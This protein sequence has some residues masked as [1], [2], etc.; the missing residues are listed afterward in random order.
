MLR[1]ESI[2]AQLDGTLSTESSS[3]K[4]ENRIDASGINV[5]DMGSQGGGRMDQKSPE[6]GGW[7]V[8]INRPPV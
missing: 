2:R 7:L 8:I 6:S 3:Q 1:A 5:Q 4:P